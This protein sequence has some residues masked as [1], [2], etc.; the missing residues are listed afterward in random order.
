MNGELRGEKQKKTGPVFLA[1]L[2]DRAILAGWIGGLVLIGLLL[3]AVTVSLRGRLLMRT[4]NRILEEE[5]IPY[6]L[7]AAMTGGKRGPG[8]RAKSPMGNRYTLVEGEGSFFV[9]TLFVE[10]I[11]IPFGALVS[12]AGQVEE[13]IPLSSHGAKTM[14]RIPQGVIDVHIRRIEAAFGRKVQ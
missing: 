2:K 12:P 14:D 5:N 10:G 7:A 6:R 4:V 3:W 11:T 1:G 8:S 13:L 9:F